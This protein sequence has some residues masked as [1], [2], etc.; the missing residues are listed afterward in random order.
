[1]N[2]LLAAPM[3][4]PLQ[5]LTADVS[6][7]CP[8]SSPAAGYHGSGSTSY[9]AALAA[10]FIEGWV[11]LLLTV[12]GARAKLITYVPRSIA[13]AMSA[14]VQRALATCPPPSLS[15]SISLSLPCVGRLLQPWLAT[16]LADHCF[17]GT[18]LCC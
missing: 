3:A 5:L 10:V 15:L 6:V 13:L 4:V 14:G 16:Q 2:A 17:S 9:G 11:F 7:P 1:M 18:E 12:T 8:H